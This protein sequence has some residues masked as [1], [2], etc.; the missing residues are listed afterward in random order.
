M[1]LTGANFY[2]ILFPS[3]AASLEIARRPLLRDVN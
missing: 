2:N 3:I 1:F